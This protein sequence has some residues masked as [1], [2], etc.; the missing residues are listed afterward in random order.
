MEDPL[1]SR[2]GARERC[3]LS[4]GIFG[5]VRSASS[6]ARKKDDVGVSWLCSLF[7]TRPLH[8]GHHLLRS[9]RA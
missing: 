5:L 2:V 4:R 1:M 6:R 3:A 9:L 7:L 8:S